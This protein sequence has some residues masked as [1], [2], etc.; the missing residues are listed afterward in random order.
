MTLCDRG[1]QAL[2]KEI[3]RLDPDAYYCLW[4]FNGFTME[5]IMDPTMHDDAIV[6]SD[7]WNLNDWH[8]H[9]NKTSADAHNNKQRKQPH[10]NKGEEKCETS[11]SLKQL[12]HPH[13]LVNVKFN[14]KTR[15]QEAPQLRRLR[16]YTDS[17][18]ADSAVAYAILVLV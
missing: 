9:K 16:G 1:R 11:K 18:I 8:A 4:H 5:T 13:I 2:M 15:R 6:L 14:V 10:E 12:P 3:E 7:T 17:A